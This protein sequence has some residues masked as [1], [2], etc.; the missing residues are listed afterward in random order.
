MKPTTISGFVLSSL[1]LSGCGQ[2]QTNTNPSLY[3]QAVQP[4]NTEYSNALACLGELIDQK[5]DRSLLVYVK[6]INDE[7]VPYRYDK[8]R[9]SQGG[10]WWLH[11]AISKLESSQVSSTVK[12]YKRGRHPGGSY[13]V[14]TGAWT[15]DDLEVGSNDKKAGYGNTGGGWLRALDWRKKNE[16]SVIA[17]D[18]LSTV[19]GKVVH[20]SAISL[21]VGSEQN[22]LSLRIDNG[23]RSMD[24]GI[25]SEKN[26]GPQFAQRRIA[27][28]AVLVHVAH[29]YN[30]DYR[31]CIEMDWASPSRYASEVSTYVSSSKRQRYKKMQEALQ[32]AGYDPGSIDG[33]WGKQSVKA[34]ASFQQTKG[35]PP[36]G[37][38]SASLYGMV[39]NSPN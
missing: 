31:P 20:A 28:A 17:G 13:L 9:L 5:S 38:P 6:D 26:E 32:S 25:V 7:T 8:R 18:F 19:S 34:L 33:V 22:G 15:Q 2:L 10:A 39:L 27:E 4:V 23:P 16:V 30:I 11:T 14:L 21:A 36:S 24:L 12:S 35:L 37:K 3:R 29:A 1:I